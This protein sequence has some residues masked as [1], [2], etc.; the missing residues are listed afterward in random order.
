M[1][2]DMQPIILFVDDNPYLKLSVNIHYGQSTRKKD[3]QTALST[4]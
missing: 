4:N 1:R 3:K 2:I